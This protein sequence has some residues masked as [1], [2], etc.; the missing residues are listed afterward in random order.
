MSGLS[1][2]AASMVIGAATAGVAGTSCKREAV[3][4][5]MCGDQGVLVAPVL[6]DWGGVATG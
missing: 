4:L 6:E 5:A 1:T 2:D 3:L